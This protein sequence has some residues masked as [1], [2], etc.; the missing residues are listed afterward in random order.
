MLRVEVTHKIECNADRAGLAG[1]RIQCVNSEIIR[2][3]R[4]EL[5][6]W[7]APLSSGKGLLGVLRVAV[8]NT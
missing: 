5:T 6:M 1:T 2:F 4:M 7:M 8:E 3:W